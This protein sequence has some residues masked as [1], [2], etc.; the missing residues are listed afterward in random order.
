ME[1]EQLIRRNDPG[2]VFVR[3]QKWFQLRTQ[4]IHLGKHEGKTT[5]TVAQKNRYCCKKKHPDF[6]SSFFSVGPIV[7]LRWEG[8]KCWETCYQQICRICPDTVCF[9]GPLSW[10]SASTC[11]APWCRTV[12]K[13]RRKHWQSKKRKS[14][15]ETNRKIMVPAA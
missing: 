15:C 1:L 3:Q 11:W 9:N 5:V 2:T 13:W 6:V 4:S 7:W 14:W 8:L 10:R 12:C